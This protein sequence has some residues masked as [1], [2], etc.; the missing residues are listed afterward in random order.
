MALIAPGSRMNWTDYVIIALLLFSCVAGLLRGLLREVISLV[1]WVAAVWLA[2][3]FADTLAPHLGGALSDAAVRP[4]A[5]R[6]I[7]FVAVLLV[8]AAVG[9]LVSRFVRLSLF[10]GLDRLLGFV[11]GLLR[12]VVAL[13]LLA[14][15]CHAVRLSDESWYRAST[16]VPYAEQAGNVLR[17]LVGERKIRASQ[18][19]A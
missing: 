9:A 6:T 10:S 1:T 17:G 3:S 7:I 12:G 14:M 4:W 16:L 15:L 8:G 18:S 5:A 13:G 2:W 11:F 19:T